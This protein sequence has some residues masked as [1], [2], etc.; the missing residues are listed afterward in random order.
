M[1]HLIIFVL[2]IIMG[3]TS[4][5][6]SEQLFSTPLANELRLQ[7]IAAIAISNAVVAF[8]KNTGQEI[9]NFWIGFEQRED[10]LVVSINANRAPG[11]RGLGGRTSMGQSMIYYISPKNGQI[12]RELGQR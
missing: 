9:K 4:L 6:Q 10:N 5:V 1:K 12:I 7:P 3:T 11:E 2:V 8:Q